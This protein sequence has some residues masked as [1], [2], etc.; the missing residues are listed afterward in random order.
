MADKISSAKRNWSEYHGVTEKLPPNPLLLKALEFVSVRNKAVDLGAG[1]LRDTR[2]LLDQGF[3]VTAVDSEPSIID[4]AAA[5]RSEKLRCH[6]GGFDTFAFPE[7]EY[8]IA[9]AIYALP[10]NPPETFDLV[11]ERIMKSLKTN[12]VFCGQFFGVNDGWNTP[13]RDMAFHTKEQI[14][15]LLEGLETVFFSEQE[16]DGPT[17]VGAPKHWH[18]FHV[19][20]KKK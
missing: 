9:S 18:V 11:F 5:L 6:A 20:A 4:G 17:A 3:E 10:F 19:I 13:G 14:E 16:K 2:F 7:N 15:K 1:S 12:G 8:D